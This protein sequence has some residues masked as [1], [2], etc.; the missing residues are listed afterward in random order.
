MS[1]MIASSAIDVNS[2][3][4]KTLNMKGY[5]RSQPLRRIGLHCARAGGVLEFAPYQYAL[6]HTLAFA[7][8]LAFAFAFASYC[9]HAI[10]SV[11]CA[12]CY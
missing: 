6:A 10:R 3:G 8:L 5:G 1:K 2:G 4:V 12:T 7:S 9:T 11:I